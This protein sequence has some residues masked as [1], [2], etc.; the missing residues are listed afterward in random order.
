MLAQAEVKIGPL[1]VIGF[2]IMK[3]KVEFE[4][5]SIYVAEP[6]IKLG[7]RYLSI[8]FLEDKSLWVALQNKIKET[9]R[10]EI[11]NQTS[12]KGVID[13]SEIDI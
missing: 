12:E 3:N 7:E 1:K 11:D 13:P 2:R 8:V 5:D 6:K 4:G 10:E 9:Y